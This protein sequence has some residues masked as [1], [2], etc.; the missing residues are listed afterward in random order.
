MTLDPVGLVYLS[1]GIATVFAALLPRLL[2]KAPVSMPMVFVGAGIVAFT[3]VPGLPDPNPTEHPVI[4]VHLTELCV[5]ISLMGA[6]LA[7]N[8]VFSWRT[9]S[10]TWRLLGITMPLSIVAVA[11]LGW[12]GLGLGAASA[13]LLGAALAPTD[14]VLASEVQ[15]A[16]PLTEDDHGDDDEARFAIT[17]EAG[18]NDGLAFPFTYAAIAIST[19]GLAP[20]GWLSEWLLIDVGWRLALGMLL[21]LGVGWL[22]RRLFFSG[23]S[24][25]LGFTDKA[26][27]FIALAATFLAYGAAEVAEGYGFLAVFVCAC[28]IRAAERAHGLH[29]VLHTFVEQVERL[30]TVAV[31][32]LLGGAVARGLLQSLTLPDIL[33]A[34]AVLLVIRPLSGWVGLTPGKTG[35]RERAVI[36]FFG[37]RGV[38]SLFYIAYALENGDFPGGERLWAIASVVVLGSILIHGVAATPTMTL[39]DRARRRRAQRPE[40]DAGATN[41]PV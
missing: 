26:D 29:S 20:S 17:S 24:Q 33:V 5:I 21:G 16:E 1:A 36:A 39:L 34:A 14:P 35:P 11:L 41:T 6:G 3:I 40:N 32:I 12:W 22:L 38:G 30:L 10:T 15:V 2:G 7:I 27:G 19:V 28:T 8:R 13:I 31:L 9:W 4:A 23:L 18:L 37:V 25:R